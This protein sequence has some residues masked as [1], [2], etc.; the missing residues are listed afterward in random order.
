MIFCNK[1]I[2]VIFLERFWMK[3]KKKK[4]KYFMKTENCFVWNIISFLVRTFLGTFYLNALFNQYLYFIMNGK[5]NLSTFWARLFSLFLLYKNFLIWK[6]WIT[7]THIFDQYKSYIIFYT[8]YI[9]NKYIW[10]R[11]SIIYWDSGRE[12]NIL[13][14]LLDAIMNW[15]NLLQHNIVLEI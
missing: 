12:F 11:I 15:Y 8:F 5:T 1:K 7:Y 2:M 3:M 4:K 13:W 10:T 9:F 6:L 14:N